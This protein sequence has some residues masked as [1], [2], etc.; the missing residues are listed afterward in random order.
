MAM[1]EGCEERLAKEVEIFLA[2]WERGRPMNALWEIE[3]HEDWNCRICTRC[4]RKVI[5]LIFYLTTF[6]S[7]IN[8]IPF[9][10][11]PLGSYS[12]M[13]TLF[14]LLIAALEVFNRYDLQ[15][16][17]YTFQGR[18]YKK[19]L[20]WQ[21]VLEEQILFGQSPTVKKNLYWFDLPFAHITYDR[22]ASFRDFRKH[23][24]VCHYF[25]ATPRT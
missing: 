15:H 10:I 22:R 2:E 12:P 17:R 20:A 13:E 6:F 23:P 11:V 9:K 7:N 4:G 25:S 21:F 24:K 14:P 18:L 16:V 19:K 8:I 3:H 1:W 5:R